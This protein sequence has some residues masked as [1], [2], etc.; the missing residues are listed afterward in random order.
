MYNMLL[1]RKIENAYGRVVQKRDSTFVNNYYYYYV[2]QSDKW[3]ES[4]E[5][6]RQCAII[7]G[8]ERDNV[9]GELAVLSTFECCICFLIDFTIIY[10][11]D[12]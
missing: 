3:M 7:T 5:K 12:V 4:N 6:V 8:Y 10:G 9:V 11:A 1:L 2:I